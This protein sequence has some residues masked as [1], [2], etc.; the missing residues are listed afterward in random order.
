MRDLIP[1]PYQ[2][3]AR[4]HLL[5]V[6]RCALYAGMGMGK[7]LSTLMA[8]DA[9]GLTSSHP[10][11]VLAPLRVARDTW[12]AEAGKWRQFSHLEMSPIVGTPAERRR[13]MQRDVP[14][15]T[16]NYEQLPML[17][18]EYGDRWPFRQIVADE[19][20]R[21][22]SFRLRQ[23]GQ[24]AAALGRVAHKHVD[25]FIE[26]TGTPS[27][28]G[29]ED[30]WGQAWMLDQGQRLG[31]TFSAFQQRWFS[32]TPG[33]QGYTSWKAKPEAQAE[34]QHLLR[35][36][37]LTLDPKDWFDLKDP[38]VNTIRVPL[39]AKARRV[40]RDMEREMF[41]SLGDGQDIEA[42]G[43][44][45]RTLKC[46]QLANG[47][48]YV[49]DDNKEF[50][51]LHDAKLQALDSIVEEAAGAP[52]LVAYH[53]RSDRARILAAFRNAVDVATPDGMAAF[54]AGKTRIGI[55]HPAS[56]GHG[57]DGLQDVCNTAAF[58]GHW[59]SMEERMQFIERIGPVRQAQSGFDRP[60]FI[61]NIVAEDTVDDLV[62]ARH[63]SKRSVQ[64]L[65][66]ESMK[67]KGLT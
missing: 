42:F 52:V 25:R 48:A 39:P 8:I 22:K 63:D 36:L 51:E 49:G 54:K 53:F 30:L 11:L 65:L 64:D 2:V 56:M 35:D 9:L 58:F 59:W 47:A 19:A 38:I 31:R 33:G 62:L 20:T 32:P 43:A 7:T 60:V 50:V 66:L 14:I 40:Y 15:Y 37:C 18:E 46:L 55:G 34:I 27:P 12:P 3:I 57:V 41:A 5:D 29:L 23:G 67:R 21:L 1:R 13:A 24:R 28:N 10:T 26:L 44:A 6:P 17:V 61:H 45:A 16:S 4:D